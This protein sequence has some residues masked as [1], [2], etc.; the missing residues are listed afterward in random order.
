[1]EEPPGARAD[2]VDVLDRESCLALLGT[3]AVGR[4]AWSDPDGRI[5]LRPVTFGLDD[6]CVAFRCG[7]GSMLTA[8]REGRPV[9]FE[10]DGIEPALRTG[11]S[12]LV[13]G[14]TAELAPP[15]AP[16][17]GPRIVDPW[18]R[19][20]RPHLVRL[21]AGQVTGRRLGPTA[22]G[23]SVVRVDPDDTAG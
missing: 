13:A 21:R 20:G 7:P 17:P 2:G 15:S 23:V 12:V 3:V 14:P 19:G 16:Q 8:I 22:G 1:V 10:A 9:S 5:Q 4:L 11:W 18:A 6:G